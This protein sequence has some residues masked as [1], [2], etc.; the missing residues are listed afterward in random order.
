VLA[1]LDVL[2]CPS[3]TH[4]NG[5]TVALE[6]LQAGTP[7]IGTRI[8]AFPENVQ[9][10]AEGCLIPP[11]DAAALARVFERLASDPSVIDTW[12]AGIRPVRTMAQ[13]AE[14][15]LNLYQQILQESCHDGL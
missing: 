13:C 10:Q 11:G 7:V 5:P 9:D 4:E 6:A 1:G 15:Y 12:R 14:D 8:G 2:C 3:V